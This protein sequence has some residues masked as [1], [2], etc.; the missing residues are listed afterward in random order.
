MSD[1]WVHWLRPRRVKKV[2]TPVFRQ[3][4]PFSVVQV[5]MQPSPAVVLP[6]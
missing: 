4:Y 1:T 2:L 5:A 6:S 3:P